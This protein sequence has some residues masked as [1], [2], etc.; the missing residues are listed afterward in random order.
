MT[1]GKRIALRSQASAL[2]FLLFVAAL[3][4]V[5][6]SLP[7]G[8]I[9]GSLLILFSSISYLFF[10]SVSLKNMAFVSAIRSDLW[11]M[12]FRNKVWWLACVAF[13]GGIALT[14]FVS[15]FLLTT[16]N[17]TTAICLAPIA[18]YLWLMRRVDRR[19][20]RHLKKDARDFLKYTVTTVLIGSVL[21]IVTII[22]KSVEFWYIA[23]QIPLDGASITAYAK[24]NVDHEF[25]WLQHIGR[26]VVKFDG[27]IVC[28]PP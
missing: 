19:L 21:F 20:Q 16:P 3:A 25:K 28:S 11:L 14:T 12:W 2:S 18:V 6:L 1:R 10:Q 7:F 5:K 8:W 26:T 4:V 9:I 23:N 27:E 22:A 17:I 13:I 15:V 24:A